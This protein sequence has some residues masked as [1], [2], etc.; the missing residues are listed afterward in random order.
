M[1]N[2][3]S[4]AVGIAA[5]LLLGRADATPRS[6]IAGT[7]RTDTVAEFVAMAKQSSP[8]TP[9][10]ELTADEAAARTEA[11]TRVAAGGYYD[12]YNPCPYSRPIQHC[13]VFGFCFCSAW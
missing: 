1:K 8:R 7:G 11:P 12:T 5:L 10:V 4:I 9:D 3:H 13:T 2:M 6:E